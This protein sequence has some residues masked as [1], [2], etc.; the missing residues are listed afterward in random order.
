MTE[1]FQNKLHQEECKQSKRAKLFASIRKEPEWEK[2]CKTFWQ[3]FA[4]QNMQIKQMQNIP[5][6][7]RAFLNQLKTFYKNV[8]PKRTPQTL[9]HLKF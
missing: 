6:P 7:L 8:A 4:R 3:I 9:P 1:N 5:L 2:C